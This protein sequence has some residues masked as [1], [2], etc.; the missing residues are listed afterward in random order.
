[1]FDHGVYDARGYWRLIVQPDIRDFKAD[2]SPRNT[3][4]VVQSLWALIEWT[5]WEGAASE[6]EAR[7]NKRG[8]LSSS[9]EMR[10]IKDAAD[11]AKHK[12]LTRDMEDTR[13]LG[14]APSGQAA[15]GHGCYGSPMGGYGSIEP[16]LTLN[17]GDEYLLR[18]VVERLD[19]FW[20]ARLT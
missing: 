3:A 13:R 8:L 19:G 12:N 5:A 7:S 18:G 1:V 17:N 14:L 9:P 11:S 15:Y 16:R 6:A 10:W 20:S 4:H 2:P